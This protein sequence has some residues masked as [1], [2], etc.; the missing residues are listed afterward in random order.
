[1]ESPCPIKIL[2]GKLVKKEYSNYKDIY[3]SYINEGQKDIE[4]VKFKWYGETVFGEPADMGSYS[5]KGFGGGFTEDKLKAGKAD[6]AT[7]EISSKDAKKIIKVWIN[8]IAFSD[9]TKWKT[10]SN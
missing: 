7:F 5:E 9:G 8:E 4:G 1:M 3:I 10:K 2:S 6:N